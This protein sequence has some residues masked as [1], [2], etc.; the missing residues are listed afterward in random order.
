MTSS[1]SVDPNLR[2]AVKDVKVEFFYSKSKKAKDIILAGDV[3][4]KRYLS[5][6]QNVPGALS[7]DGHLFPNVEHA[8]HYEK[9]KRSNKPELGLRYV[10]VPSSFS[11][12]AKAKIFS[13]R[14][15]M[16]A[17]GA[18]LDIDR[19]N[20]DRVDVNESLLKARFATDEKFRVILRESH[21]KN[22]RLLHFERGSLK[23]PPFW[24]ALKLKNNGKIIG[25]NMLGKQLMNLLNLNL[26][27]NLIQGTPCDK[28]Q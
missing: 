18:T 2:S 21:A 15:T 9:F 17:N 1:S 5:N 11:T 13:G 24:G 6:F 3:F 20:R 12:N 25:K 14:K 19:W 26:H 7:W 10:G 8:F 16:R 28:Q 4:W 22:V 27:L 23:R